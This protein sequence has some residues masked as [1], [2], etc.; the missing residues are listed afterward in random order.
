MNAKN[1]LWIGLG[2]LLLGIVL[3]SLLKSQVLVVFTG[4]LTLLLLAVGLMFIAMGIVQVRE[5]RD[6][7][8]K[9]AEEAARGAQ[10]TASE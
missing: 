5:A 1:T 8:R 6:N 10:M 4:G 3:F 7:E 2:L 9:E